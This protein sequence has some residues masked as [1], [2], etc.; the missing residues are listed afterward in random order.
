MTPIKTT[1]LAASLLVLLFLLQ[2]VP[3]RGLPQPAAPTP[4]LGDARHL[5]LAYQQWKSRQAPDGVFTVPLGW[6]KGLSSEPSQAVGGAHGQA[7]F[8]LSTGAVSVEVRDL[9]SGLS[10]EAWLVDNG[11]GGSA[12]P[13]SGDAVR[14]LGRL[15]QQAGVATL[16]ALLEAEALLAFEVD[17]VVVTRQGVRPE[18]G[19]LLFGM[20]TLFQRLYR[21]EVQRP[22]QTADG[23]AAE[24]AEAQAS[25]VLAVGPVSAYASV[26]GV[27]LA[28]LDALVDE[29]ERLFF[30]ETFGGNGRTCG[31][32]HP[33]ENNLTIDPAF[34]A[35]LPAD[36]PLFVAEFMP[37]LNFEQNGGLRF[38]NPVL[39]RQ[40]AL[41][42]ENLDGFEDPANKFTMRSVSHVFA[43]ALSIAPSPDDGTDPS[44][45]ART[46]WSG[47]GAARSRRRFRRPDRGARAHG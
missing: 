32:C 45:L 34:I 35:T 36:N 20:P 47:D 8:N 13:E 46:G 38:E 6:S 9:P 43:Q 1:I 10:V 23:V 37:A 2:A 15:A 12:R 4:H 19:G 41:I 24:D 14:Y 17:V 42:V 21:S 27:S 22:W 3:W 7:R 33:A 18:S 5:H 11:S 28:Q 16:E 39:M 26:A 40:F 31:T 29:G 25:G 30:N 44:V